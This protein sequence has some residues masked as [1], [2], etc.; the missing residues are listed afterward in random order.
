M[1]LKEKLK[2]EQESFEWAKKNR[3]T[4]LAEV[5][6]EKQEAVKRVEREYEGEI[7]QLGRDVYECNKVFMKY[8]R[9]QRIYST[10]NLDLLGQAIAQLMS[11]IEKKDFEFLRLVNFYKVYKTSSADFRNVHIPVALV[12][13][14]G[15]IKKGTSLLESP[16]EKEDQV[17]GLINE[18]KALQLF[19]DSAF[20]SDGLIQVYESNDFK[21]RKNINLGNFTYIAEFINFLVE[22][23]YQENLRDFTVNDLVRGMQVFILEYADKLG[24][25]YQGQVLKF[26]FKSD[27][28]A[29]S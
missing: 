22:Y 27:L 20:R 18:G 11:V 25:N 23:R 5:E 8:Q 2:E 4:L 16:S 7:L 10:F 14:K 3:T 12:I 1:S 13:E 19:K 21:L 26:T 17:D 24:F 29:E 28:N 15:A 9:L 6:R